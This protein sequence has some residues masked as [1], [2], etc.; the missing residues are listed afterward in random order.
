MKM[1]NKKVI[2]LTTLAVA[3]ASIFFGL[4]YSGVLNPV[5]TGAMYTSISH[6]EN[7]LSSKDMPFT[8]AEAKSQAYKMSEEMKWS[9]NSLDHCF[10]IYSKE[11]CYANSKGFLSVKPSGFGYVAGSEVV[12]TPFY[13]SSLINSQVLPSGEVVKEGKFTLSRHLNSQELIA[14]TTAQTIK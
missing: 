7:S 1:K 13:D 5:A 11:S 4:K 8:C 2:A 6:C 12:P 3:S 14:V 9:F 10:A